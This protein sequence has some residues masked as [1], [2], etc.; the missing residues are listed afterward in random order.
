LFSPLLL[1]C[2]MAFG[3]AAYPSRVLAQMA[4]D[5][6]HITPHPR[7][8]RPDR[9]AFRSDVNLVLVNVTVADFQGRLVSELGPENF[10][11]LEDKRPQQLRYFSRE[12]E[13]LSVA[14]ILDTSQSMKAHMAQARAAA[15]AFVR[16]SNPED[17]FVLITFADQP[18]L[19]ASLADSEPEADLLRFTAGVSAKGNTALWDAV[20]LGV[21]K[22]RHARHGRRALL[23]ISDGG[24]NHSRYTQSEIKSLLEEADVQ[25]YG[26][27]MLDPAPMKSAD[28]LGLLSLDEIAGATG[29]RIFPVHDL[30]E[31]HRA[32]DQI[33]L[34][35]RTQYVL[36][37]Y[38]SQAAQAANWRKI[39]VEVKNFSD[40]RGLHIYAKKGYSL[41]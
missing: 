34:A 3:A 16:D 35:L 1:L 11:I 10:S 32:I 26:I 7:S 20:H 33:S 19:V 25:V 17:E 12:E 5:E 40:S 36:G 28:R 2:L 39:K 21:R 27:D 9:A 41:K 30:A 37:Y 6:V 22:L 15:L 24:D 13:P 14:I 4:A 31:L 18:R 29:G 23:V 38:P 8:V